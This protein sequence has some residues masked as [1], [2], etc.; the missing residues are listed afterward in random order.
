MELTTRDYSVY[1]EVKRRSEL[2]EWTNVQHLALLCGCTKRAIRR[3]V[4]R[5]RESD[6]IQK[7]ILTDYKKGYK[8]MSVEDEFAMLTKTKI[9]ILKEFKRYWKDVERYNRNNQNKI[10]FT[11]YER[12]FY[13]SLV[14]VKKC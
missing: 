3:C 10:T 13:E 12:D 2:N 8:L 14:E 4:Q 7:I 9:K 6:K 11:Q 1:N 5:I